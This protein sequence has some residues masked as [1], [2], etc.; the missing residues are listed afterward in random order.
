MIINVASWKRY[1]IL[2]SLKTMAIFNNI[3][4]DFVFMSAI[5]TILKALV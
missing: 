4:P 2:I 3:S 5:L 1:A